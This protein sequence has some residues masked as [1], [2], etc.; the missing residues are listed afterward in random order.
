M[1]TKTHRWTRR[2][3]AVW[4][5][6]VLTAAVIAGS[7]ALSSPADSSTH[8]SLPVRTAGQ[9]LAAAESSVT[10]PLSGTVVETARLGLPALPTAG[11]TA[12]LDWQTLV[13]GSHTALVWTDGPTKQR[14]ALTGQLSESDV[15]HNGRDLWTYTS[16]TNAAS[17][18][19]LSGQDA[20]RAS[21]A[22][23][24]YTPAQAAAA[25]LKAIAPTTVVSIDRTQV[26]AGQ[27]AY[28]LVLTPRDHRS[29]VSR[30]TI[31]LDSKHFVP[32]RVQLF[33]SATKPA[34]EVGFTSITFKTPAASVFNFVVPKG[35]TVVSN[36]IEPQQH[37]VH[38]RIRGRVPSAAGGKTM[39]TAQPA[40]NTKVIGSGWTAIVEMR[41]GVP[42]GAASGLLVKA[43]HPVGSAGA[44]LITTS[45]LN[46]L[47]LSDGRVF[48]GA[49]SSSMLQATAA[50]TPR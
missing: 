11:T 15:I 22:A 49:V 7:V 48:L 32:L 41:G 40:A 12:S 19:V 1:E 33:G 37:T 45:L 2:R 39:P 13:T 5:V 20:K 3:R 46:V 21:G 43:S 10:V 36:P 17:H 44:R 4:G 26:V 50:A 42:A 34:F 47:I 8:P 31:A 9:L 6:P 18:S 30:V 27:K 28:T 14:L 29:T 25:A 24:T 16:A 38:A 23:E 35:A